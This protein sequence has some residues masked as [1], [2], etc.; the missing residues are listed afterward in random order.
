MRW[1]LLERRGKPR[2]SDKSSIYAMEWLKLMIDNREKNSSG[3]AFYIEKRR[4]K[5][6]LFFFLGKNNE[7]LWISV[8][9]KFNEEDSLRYLY[10]CCGVGLWCFH[11]KHRMWYLRRKVEPIFGKSRWFLVITLWW[12]CKSLSQF[13]LTLWIMYNVLSPK[14]TLQ[15][16][17]RFRFKWGVGFSH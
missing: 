6:V 17:R 2:I 12:L 8:Y 4:W 13:F 9:L 16:C 5:C 10:P 15:I 11:R 7:N 1:T 14:R 3:S